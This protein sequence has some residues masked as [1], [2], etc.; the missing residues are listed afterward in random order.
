[1]KDKIIFWLSAELLRFGLAKS[2]SEKYDCDLFAIID[3]TDK[4]K[5]FFEEQKIVKFE[6]QWFYHDH[7]TTTKKPDLNYLKNFEDKYKINLWLLAFNERIFQ[8]NDY[9]HFTSDEILSILEQ[10]CKLFEKILEVNPDFI[11]LPTSAFHHSHLFFELC[12]AK[13]I[14]RLL[15]IPTRFGNR[16]MVTSENEP[17]DYEI[18]GIKQNPRTFKELQDYLNE[19]SFFKQLLNYQSRFLNSRSAMI[20][21]ALQYFI[22]SNN[23]NIKTHYTYYGRT[24]FKVLLKSVIGIL[25]TKYRKRFIDKNFSYE[26]NNDKPFI[27]FPLHV[28]PE[29]SLLITAPFYLNQV[30]IIKNIVKSLP[31]GYKLLVK[32]HSAMIFREW[33][34]ISVY[35]EIMSC[36]EVELLHPKVDTHKIV[37]NSSLVI[38]IS[39]TT[40]LDAAFYEKSSIVLSDTTFSKL[41]SVYRLK[42]I[43]EL[44]NAIRISLKKKVESVHVDEYVDY[45]EKNSFEFAYPLAVQDYQDFFHYGGYLVDV[46][47]TEEKMKEYIRQYKTSFDLLADEHIKKI[48]QYKNKE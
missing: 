18:K 48:K 40:A 19:H 12:K 11:I 5:K 22:F 39:G 14:K 17:L 34:K 31:P 33:R 1:M 9:Y 28:E 3:I 25:K 6:K 26:L 37:K 13:N 7:I 43:E 24:K 30:E 42:S 27:F 23:T 8:Y 29:R 46:E 45:I 16:A 44:P 21:A 32:E 35:K 2:F 36:P 20:K 15:L 47:I 10:E 4:P 38:T 41:P